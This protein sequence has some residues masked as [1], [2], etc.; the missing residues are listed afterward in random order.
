MTLVYGKLHQ[1]TRA[2]TYLPL[3]LCGFFRSNENKIDQ[4][5]SDA[6]SDQGFSQVLKSLR[7]WRPERREATKTAVQSK[8]KCSAVECAVGVK[9]ISARDQIFIVNDFDFV[10]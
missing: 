1:N 10:D 4:L 9:E 8:S 6:T 2:H 3:S 7:E 5:G